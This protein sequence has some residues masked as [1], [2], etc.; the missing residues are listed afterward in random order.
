VIRAGRRGYA[1]IAAPLDEA[2]WRRHLLGEQTLALPLSDQGR[3]HAAVIDVDVVR[4]VFDQVRA[5]PEG[6]RLCLQRTHQ[7]A[8]ALLEAA[9]SRGLDARLEDSGQKGRHVWLFFE[10]VAP[11]ATVHRLLRALIEAAGEPPPGVGCETIPPSSRAQG[12]GMSALVTLPLGVH[13]QSGRRSLFLEPDGRLVIDVER[14][15]ASIHPCSGEALRQALRGPPEPERIDAPLELEDTRIDAV[16]AGCPVVARLI[17]KAGAIGHL[18][19]H[20]RMVLLC[21][22]GHFGEE[23]AAVIHRVIERCS[24][25]DPRI[26]Q[27]HIDRLKPLPVSCNR[28]REWLPDVVK[29]VPCRCRFNVPKGAYPTPVLHAVAGTKEGGR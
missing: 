21:T 20:E 9:R 5:D 15:V 19:H 17:E 11:A 29:E 24:N 13:R 22:L 2:A 26:T 16:I 4:P 27:K 10:P 18:N 6:L 23:G 3:L 1:P 8:R 28:V 14:Y 7:H 12:S 25:Y